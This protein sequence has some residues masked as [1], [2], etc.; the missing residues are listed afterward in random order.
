MRA[1]APRER[2]TRA[3]FLLSTCIALQATAAFSQPEAPTSQP[4]HGITDLRGDFSV[5]YALV[6]LGGDAAPNVGPITRADLSFSVG[7]REV[8][9]RLDPVGIR[10][11]GFALEVREGRDLFSLTHQR[12]PS[13]GI[14]PSRGASTDFQ[15]LVATKPVGA[16]DLQ[17]LVSVQGTEGSAGTSVFTARLAASDRYRDPFEGV[18]SVDWR[19]SAQSTNLQVAATGQQ[20]S[21]VTFSVGAGAAFGGEDARSLRPSV[22]LDLTSEDA[23]VRMR[24]DTNLSAE[25]TPLEDVSVGARWDFRP[26]GTAD[27]QS[28]S[29]TTSRLDPVAIN[30]EAD[31]SRAADGS[32]AYR[33]GLGADVA[34]G[35]GYRVGGSYRGEADGAGTGHG[36]RGRFSARWQAPGLTV[37]GSLDGG[38]I[39]RSDGELRPDVSASLAAVAAELGPLSGSLAGS[40]RYQG[41]L[42]GA[43]NGAFRLDLDRVTVDVDGEVSYANSLSLSGGVVT[44]FEVIRQEDRSLSVQLGLEGRSTQGGASAASLDLGLRYGFGE[45]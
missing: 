27:S 44:A 38:A 41:Q 8:S 30:A 13:D 19:A 16:P 37:R 33:W 5:S 22:R 7:P 31:R 11:Q 21:S 9:L 17:A 4:P 18:S 39:W 15:V 34:L 36:A 12:T 42:S 29:V 3:L 2:I 28:L 23:G 32:T 6:L 35:S 40:L 45:R 14:D 26:V 1:T 43:L 25:V 24:L 20:R 10:R